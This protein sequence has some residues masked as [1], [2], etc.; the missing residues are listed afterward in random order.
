MTSRIMGIWIVRIIYKKNPV[1]LQYAIPYQPVPIHI[2]SLPQAPIPISQII[3][4][5]FKTPWSIAKTRIFTPQLHLIRRLRPRNRAEVPRVNSLLIK[6][7]DFFGRE[8]TDF[9]YIKPRKN[10]QDDAGSHINEA[11]FGSKISRSYIVHIRRYEG[12]E[13]WAEGL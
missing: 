11:G 10:Q 3:S 2:P 5:L 6:M 13:P 1:T 4:Q 8:A 9:W 7:I 12:E